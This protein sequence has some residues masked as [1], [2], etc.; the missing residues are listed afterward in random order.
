M[1][2]YNRTTRL[3]N[4]GRNVIRDAMAWIVDDSNERKKVLW[5]Y[6]WGHR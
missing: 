2:G 6:G 1:D 4:T 5:V 3:E